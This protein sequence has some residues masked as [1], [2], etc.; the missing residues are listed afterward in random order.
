MPATAVPAAL[1]TDKVLVR[2]IADF[3]EEIG[4]CE[5]FLEVLRTTAAQGAVRKEMAALAKRM[6]AALELSDRAAQAKVVAALVKDAAKAANAASAAMSAEV[7][8]RCKVA[9]AKA[10]GLLAQALVEVGALEPQALRLSLQKEQTTLRAQLDRLEQ[11]TNKGLST[12]VE[13]EE[14]IVRCTALLQRVGAAAPAGQW[15]RTVYTPLVARVRASIERVPVERCRK[16]LL[17]ELD[18]IDVDVAKALLKADAKAAQARS[19]APLQRI[20]RLAVQIVAA[21]PALDR[22]L[23]R[24]GKQLHGA[25]GAAPALGKKLKALIQ[26]RTTSWPAGADVGG[27][28]AALAAFEAG[29]ARLAA[30]IGKAASAPVRA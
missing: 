22:E 2:L 3:D 15:M 28:A 17:A 26:A 16:T 27:I 23:A 21:A 4:T 10:R 7:A 20:D 11:E 14:L 30:E 18:F 8:E 12:V 1:R 25:P 5:S 9:W 24:L 29:L 6:K 13:L 19:I